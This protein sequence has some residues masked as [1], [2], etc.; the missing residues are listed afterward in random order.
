MT[1]PVL[2]AWSGGKDS[3]LSVRALARDPSIR[4]H[5]LLSTVTDAYDRVSMHGVRRTLLEMQAAALELPLVQIRIPSPCDNATYEALMEKALIRAKA[6]GVR[7]CA[8]GDLFLQDIRE[9]R[10]R[11]L[12]RVQMEALYP[13]WGIDTAELA[14]DFIRGGF[15]AILVCVD[16]RKLDPEFCGRAFDESLLADLPAGIDPCGENGEFHTF[17]HAGPIFRENLY[18]ERGELVERDGFWYCDLI[19]DER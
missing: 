17:V 11:Q 1:E 10:D 6:E 16:P 7:R 18:V 9:Y 13:V 3:A 15:E 12:A 4:I 5:A 14:L 2:M 19:P 8:F